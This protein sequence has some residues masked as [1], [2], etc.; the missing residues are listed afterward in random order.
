MAQRSCD[1]ALLKGCS[2][3]LY[4]PRRAG[5]PATWDGS[6]MLNV[7]QALFNATWSLSYAWILTICTA[8]CC[9]CSLMA[10]AEGRSGPPTAHI[11]TP[12]VEAAAKVNL[13]F[14]MRL[15]WAIEVARTLCAPSVL[16]AKGPRFTD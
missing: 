3:S 9:C 16:L 5:C 6:Q 8:S 7:F 1:G 15:V 10:G 2:S 13:E 12:I 14:F 11:T 4:L